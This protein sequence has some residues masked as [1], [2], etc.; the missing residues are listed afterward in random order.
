MNADG[1]NQW[2]LVEGNGGV[3]GR[4]RAASTFIR[5]E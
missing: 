2:T 1:E 3:R 5:D 4:I